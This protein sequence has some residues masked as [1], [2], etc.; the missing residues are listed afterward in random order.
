MR[1]SYSYDM[2]ANFPARVSGVIALDSVHNSADASAHVQWFQDQAK[3]R[4]GQASEAE[5]PEIKAWRKAY[6]AMGFKPT[7]Y[8]CAAEA[9]LRRYRKDGS[10]PGIHPLIDLCNAVSI[11]MAIPIAVFDRDRIEGDLEVRQATGS[12]SY[13]AFSGALEHPQP[14]EVIF[15]DSAGNAHARRW[16]NKQSRYS[17]V[18]DHTCRALIVAEALHD[19]AASDMARLI[20]VLSAAL[21]DVYDVDL[22]RHLMLEPTDSIEVL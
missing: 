19:S 10:L 17:A 22:S 21:K 8:R 1:F 20:D 5:F 16:A 18:A 6:S 9:L 3:T 4:L 11:A 7:K 13:L 15:A 12:E 14:Q 2:Q